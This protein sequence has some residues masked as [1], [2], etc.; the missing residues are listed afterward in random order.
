MSHVLTLNVNV[1]YNGEYIVDPAVYQQEH[2]LART[3]PT[4][5]KVGE[6]TGD[7]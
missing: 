4:E 6:Q 7:D 5:R 2:N 3:F 1:K